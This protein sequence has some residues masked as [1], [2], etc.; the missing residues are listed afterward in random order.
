MR[1]SYR[2]SKFSF[3]YPAEQWSTPS[4]I[5]TLQ[6]R[7]DGLAKV[8]IEVDYRLP[9]TQVEALALLDRN[10]AEGCLACLSAAAN[11]DGLALLIRACD[12]PVRPLSA[13]RKRD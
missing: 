8:D 9:A 10:D 6:T 7:L 3:S 12:A 2:S 11:Q 1:F 13:M 5:V 4:S